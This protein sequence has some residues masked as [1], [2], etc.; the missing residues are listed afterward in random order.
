M[1]LLITHA[2]NDSEC[3]QNC[4]VSQRLYLYNTLRKTQTHKRQ[5]SPCME[6][7]PVPSESFNDLFNYSNSTGKPSLDLVV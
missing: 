6:Q 1:L 7:H 3:P 4:L 5:M 2:A